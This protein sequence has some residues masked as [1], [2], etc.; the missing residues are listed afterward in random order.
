M[1]ETLYTL[2]SELF[3]PTLAAFFTTVNKCNRLR[4]LAH[5]YIWYIGC[6]SK[7]TDCSSVV[8]AF[9]S[10]LIVLLSIRWLL[11]LSN[12]MS[13]HL[14]CVHI[15]RRRIKWNESLVVRVVK[16]SRIYKK[17]FVSAYAKWHPARVFLSD[18]VKWNWVKRNHK[19]SVHRFSKYLA[20]VQISS[21]WNFATDNHF[22]QPF[23]LVIFR[24][25]FFLLKRRDNYYL[26]RTGYILEKKHTDFS[27][28]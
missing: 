7:S 28:G 16:D 1:Y 20:E 26:W 2:S 23:Q 27:I 12:N 3:H 14:L 13:R 19:K 4:T 6:I 9:L 15:K 25:R 24:A 18:I 11:S 21:L 22:F 5:G 17:K 8:Q 10:L